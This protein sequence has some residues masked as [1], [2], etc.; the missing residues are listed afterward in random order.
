MRSRSRGIGGLG[1]LGWAPTRTPSSLLWAP[2]AVLLAARPSPPSIKD[3]HPPLGCAEE[4][5]AHAEEGEGGSRDPQRSG[6]RDGR[7]GRDQCRQPRPADWVH[8]ACVGPWIPCATLL[9]LFGACFASFGASQRGVG[10]LVA[11][12]GWASSEENRPR[13]SCFSRGHAPVVDR[14][15]GAERRELRCRTLTGRPHARFDEA[16]AAQP[17]RATRAHNPPP[18]TFRGDPTHH[19]RKSPF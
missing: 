2:W 10:V 19:R 6:A 18:W 17:K 16:R 15:R 8:C 1:A 12:L 11:R 7:C 9:P 14:H 5:G 4:G 3:P 13:R